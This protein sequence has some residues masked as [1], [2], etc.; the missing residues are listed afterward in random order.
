MLGYFQN[1]QTIHDYRCCFENFAILFI[2]WPPTG[3]WP[4]HAAAVDLH[5]I[6]VTYAH[7]YL[8]R[9]N[10]FTGFW[11]TGKRIN[12]QVLACWVAGKSVDQYPATEATL[13]ATD[14]AIYLGNRISTF[15]F[16][17]SF[18]ATASKS[19]TEDIGPRH[20]IWSFSSSFPFHPASLLS[21]FLSGSRIIDPQPPDHAHLTPLWRP[22]C[23]LILRTAKQEAKI[24]VT[25]D[26]R[27]TFQV[28]MNFWKN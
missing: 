10:R 14:R 2:H 20:L 26:S 22:L 11:L 24:Q 9:L 27:K 12:W 13:L 5:K 19:T 16:F 18:A 7:F 8:L 17:F 6:T 1:K 3:P 23:S 25:R 28:K 21:P 15:S 4:S